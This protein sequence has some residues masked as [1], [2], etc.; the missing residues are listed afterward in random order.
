VSCIAGCGFFG[1]ATTENYC[2]RCYL[3]KQQEQTDTEKEPKEQQEAEKAKAKG[4]GD[5]AGVDGE[6]KNS[7]TAEAEPKRAKQDNKSKC[8]TCGKRCGLTGFE[9]VCR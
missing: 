3:K 8:W 9:C 7:S 4:G 6:A 2:S 5:T 1:A